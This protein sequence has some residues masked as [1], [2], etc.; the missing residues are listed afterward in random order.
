MQRHLV[1]VAARP[2]QVARPAKVIVLEDAS[3]G[4]P[5]G[6]PATSRASRGR[7]HDREEGAASDGAAPVAL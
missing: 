2:A 7:P 3:E 6:V 1:R 5:R 4:A